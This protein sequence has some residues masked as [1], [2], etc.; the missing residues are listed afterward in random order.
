[1]VTSFNEG[2]FELIDKMTLHGKR[3][4]TK[5]RKNFIKSPLKSKK[6]QKYYTCV[7][8]HSTSLFGNK[9]LKALG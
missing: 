1:M 9:Q 2:D 7:F 5:K 6:S 4:F 3:G 8:H